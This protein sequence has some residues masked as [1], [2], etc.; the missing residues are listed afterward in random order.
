[1]GSDMGT[2]S[3]REDQTEV[4]IL[5]ARRVGKRIGSAAP[6][7]VAVAGSLRVLAHSLAL[8]AVEIR[9]I[10]AGERSEAFLLTRSFSFSW[11]A[12]DRARRLVIVRSSTE[13]CTSGG[14]TSER[15]STGERP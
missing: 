3:A 10:L 2:R 1:M 13:S 8:E 14:P 4:N 11:R 7:R 9:R 15:T 12:L 6:P 5:P